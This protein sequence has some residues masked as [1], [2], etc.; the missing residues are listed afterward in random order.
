MSASEAPK[1]DERECTR[2]HVTKPLDAVHF[3]PMGANRYTDGR[4]RDGSVKYTQICKN[5]VYLK[6]HATHEEKRRKD[7]AYQA[8]KLAQSASRDAK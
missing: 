3:N 7:A 8:W 5:C 6:Q 2:C 1:M 4:N